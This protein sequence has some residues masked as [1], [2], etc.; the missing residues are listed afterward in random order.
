[1]TP[2]KSINNVTER[3]NNVL[4][5][6]TNEG[7]LNNI[8]LSEVSSILKILKKS[9]TSC[10]SKY[11]LTYVKILNIKN[12]NV[13]FKYIWNYFKEKFYVITN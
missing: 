8:S 4:T 3:K 7:Q 5:Q 11:T 1:M 2:T 12:I 6:N 13:I 9:I 10:P